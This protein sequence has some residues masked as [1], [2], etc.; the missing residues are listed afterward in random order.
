MEF[1]GFDWDRGNWPKC[2]SH[3]VTKLEIELVLRGELIT[4]F[5]PEPTEQRLRAVGKNQTGRS[6]FVVYTVRETDG[7]R[8]IRPISARFMHDKEV[9]R[10]EPN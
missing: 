8:L 9:R 3:G 6:V 1:D 4:N 2:G 7:R 5:D 10:Y